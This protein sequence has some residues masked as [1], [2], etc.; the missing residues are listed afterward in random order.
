MF[1]VKHFAPS[2]K[3][4]NKTRSD[5]LPSKMFLQADFQFHLTSVFP[6]WKQDGDD[7]VRIS[8]A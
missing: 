5:Y 8:T 4:T 7:C 2:N 1:H 6:N 3:Q